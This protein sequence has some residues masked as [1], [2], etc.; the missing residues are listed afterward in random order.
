GAVWVGPPAGVGA[1]VAARAETFLSPSRSLRVVLM[2]MAP[3]LVVTPSRPSTLPTVSLVVKPWLNV[4][5]WPA[6][7]TAAARAWPTLLPW[8]RL[9][10]L[11]ARTASSGTVMCV[12]AG[13]GAPPPGWSGRGD[14]AAGLERQGQHRR[15]EDGGRHRDV[16]GR[17]VA[18]LEDAAG[19]DL[20]Q[21][22]VGEVQRARRVQRRAEVDGPAGA[23][24]LQ[25]HP[26]G[27]GVG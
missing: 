27:A 23:L 24:G 6:P 21:L 14:A 26:A 19:L 18:D 11:T 8:P 5:P 2:A 4:K 12:P 13:W 7:V 25:R 3:P 17:G 22:G 9:T 16:A 1:M 20:V 15:R 10:A